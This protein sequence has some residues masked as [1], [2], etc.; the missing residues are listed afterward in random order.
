MTVKRFNIKLDGKNYDVFTIKGESKTRLLFVT[1]TKALN[2]SFIATDPNNDDGSI[3]NVF[4]NRDN[5]V[6]FLGKDDAMGAAFSVLSFGLTSGMNPLGAN[7]TE[8]LLDH[9]SSKTGGQVPSTSGID[10]QTAIC[11][12]MQGII[13]SSIQT[14]M[15]GLLTPFGI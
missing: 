12:T 1:D 7:F 14:R 3:Y 2:S 9:L 15:E 8:G 13:L 6:D 5:F 11:T 4:F 10:K